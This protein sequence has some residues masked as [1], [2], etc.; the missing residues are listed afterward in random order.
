M[1]YGI[2]TDIVEISRMELALQKWKE[3][4]I[5]R[6]FSATES[7]YCRKRHNEAIHFAARFAAKE[8]CLKSL[9][10]GLGGGLALK[11][12]EV[13]NNKMGKPELTIDRDLNRILKRQGRFE[14]HLS[15]THTREY[16]A[17]VVLCVLTN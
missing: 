11:D 2:G 1:I 6:I 7:A 12:I 8:A 5:G 3:R 9:G 17:A 16:A 4:F 13:V 10:L 15:L 14:F